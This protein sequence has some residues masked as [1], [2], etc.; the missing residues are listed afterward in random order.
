MS[1]V[2]DLGAS[3]ISCHHRLTKKVLCW[4]LHIIGG[5]GENAAPSAFELHVLLAVFGFE[6]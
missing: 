4:R 2:L 1:F 5:A 3:K 6:A